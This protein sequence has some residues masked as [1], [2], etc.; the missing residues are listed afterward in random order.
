MR[1]EIHNYFFFFG[2]WAIL[3]VSSQI[4]TIGINYGHYMVTIFYWAA[5]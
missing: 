3:S 1:R 5:H 2:W 4:M